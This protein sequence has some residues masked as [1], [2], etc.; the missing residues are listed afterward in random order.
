MK[1]SIEIIV[2]DVNDVE[3]RVYARLLGGEAERTILHGTLRGP[4][5]EG[6]RTLPV[7]IAFHDL[8]PEQPGLAAALVP[9]PCTWSPELPHLYQA[10]VEA[11]QSGQVVAE[12][13]GKIGLRRAGI[14]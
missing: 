9:D 1:P 12:Y 5:C 14:S 6:S 10:D 2:G 3:A 7:E 11:R 4:Y 13:H 8:G